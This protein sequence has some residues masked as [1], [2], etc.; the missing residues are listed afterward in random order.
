M[1]EIEARPQ[2]TQEKEQTAEQGTKETEEAQKILEKA[3]MDQKTKCWD[4]L[5]ATLQK[6]NFKFDISTIIRS[7]GKISHQLDLTR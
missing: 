3:F 7:D 1:A 6:H 4:E 5:I 2:K